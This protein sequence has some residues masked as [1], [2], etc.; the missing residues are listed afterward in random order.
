MSKRNVYALYQEGTTEKVDKETF[1]NLGL[2]LGHVLEPFKQAPSTLGKCIRA[3]RNN[4][5]P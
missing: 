4:G 1:G 5:R 2:L 3:Q